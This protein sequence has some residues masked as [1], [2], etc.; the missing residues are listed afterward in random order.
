[1]TAR[2]KQS[3]PDPF[4][5]PKAFFYQS[6]F[7]VPFSVPKSEGVYSRHPQIENSHRNWQRRKRMKIELPVLFLV[8][9][10]WTGGHV[11]AAQMPAGP[12]QSPAVKAPQAQPPAGQ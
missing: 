6:S 11:I 8:A 9:G 2:K 10:F 4:V 5:V 12:A 1:M 7:V 3:E